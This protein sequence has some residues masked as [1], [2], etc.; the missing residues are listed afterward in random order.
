M[1]IPFEFKENQ[2]NLWT[3]LCIDIEHHLENYGLFAKGVIQNYTGVH[4]LRGIQICSN[5]TVRG[6]YTSSNV[7]DWENLPKEM[8][9]KMVKGGKWEEAYNFIYMPNSIDPIHK[10]NEMKE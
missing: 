4:T 9:F 8:A 10:K 3:I 6:I 5:M 2:R 7:Y 1:K